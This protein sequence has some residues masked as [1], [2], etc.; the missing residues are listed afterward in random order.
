MFI[1][2]GKRMMGELVMPLVAHGMGRL[3]LLP[4]GENVLSSQFTRWSHLSFC[5]ALFQ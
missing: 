4:E 1:H 5:M 2:G 3:F